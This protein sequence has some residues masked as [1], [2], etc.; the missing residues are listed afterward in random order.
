MNLRLLTGRS[1]TRLFPSPS[2]ALLLLSLISCSHTDPFPV[3]EEPQGPVSPT[4]PTRL[5]FNLFQDRAPTWRPDGS[6]LLYSYQTRPFSQPV[7]TLRDGDWCLAAMPAAGGTRSEKC[8]VSEAEHDSVDV[9][10]Q[11][12]VGPGNRLAWVS[13]HGRVG[14]LTPSRGGIQLG[15]FARNDTGATL[16]SLPYLAPDGRIHA[17]A[18]HLGWLD[19]ATLIYVGTDVQY[20]AFCNGCPMD[21]LP[22]GRDIVRLDVGTTPAGL[23]LIPGTSEATS[24]WPAADGSAIY[25]TLAGDTRVLRQVLA[26][27]AVSVVHDFGALGIARDASV[28]DSNLVAVV[29]GSVSYGVDSL[30]GPL[31]RDFGGDLYH[32]DLR[33]GTETF[34]GF[35]NSLTRRP[36]L[37]P[38]ARRIAAEAYDIQNSPTVADIFLFQAP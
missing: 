35:P 1:G 27:G 5:S 8:P 32:V 18:T 34:L 26:G 16:R 36:V 23:T 2:A 25:Y 28:V 15:S 13:H 3:G 12:A 7:D 14:L 21:T 38:D 17:T 6:G 30:L 33:T 19:A 4:F 22:I 10:Q 11:V 29:G 20:R 31:Q 24:V 37:S 9:Y